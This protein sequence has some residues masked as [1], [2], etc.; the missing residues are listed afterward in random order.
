MTKHSVSHGILKNVT[1]NFIGSGWL[2]FLMFFSTPYIVRSFNVDLYGIYTL[3]FV[4]ISYLSF[5]QFG[6]TQATIRAI[7]Q[8]LALND[9]ENARI[10][11]WACM[12]F[13]IC[14]GLFGMT[15]I[16]LFAR[17]ILVTFAKIAPQYQSIA[18]VSLRIS[19]TAFLFGVTT[20]ALTGVLRALGRF[21]IANRIS[22]GTG[23]AQIGGTV[24]LLT[25]HYSLIHIVSFVALVQLSGL[26]VYS[27]EVYKLV[28]WILHP[29]WDKN[30]FVK[31]F[32]FGGF[33]SIISITDPIMINSDKIFITSLRSVASLT[34]YSIPY[35]IVSRLTIIPSAFM[36]VMF[37]MFSK[38]NQIKDTNANRELYIRSILYMMYIYLIMMFFI[39]TFGKQFLN[40]WIGEDFAVRSSIPLYILT[41]SGFISTS[42]TPSSTLLLA[43]GRPHYLALL[44]VIETIIYVPVSYMLIHKYGSTGAASALLLCTFL[45]AT[46]LQLTTLKV[47]GIGRFTFLRK[48][49]IPM[50]LPLITG[51]TLFF[52]LH[53]LHMK[54]T[55]PLN[56]LSLMIIF[57]IYGAVVWHTGLDEFAR[58]RLREFI[59][60]IF[61]RS[62]EDSPS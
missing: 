45:Y 27:Y 22:I 16:M 30:A 13:Y 40:L 23:T 29:S 14:I 51:G 5:L 15:A 4:V 46:A 53:R 34:Y 32:K 58:C 21:D 42:A 49:F 25:F 60:S 1:W 37:P 20:G 18:I 59:A 55:A 54:L 33:V 61:S 12:L 28:P 43:V 50:V 19:S 52:I 26:L 11:F 31:L 3:V 35:T 9:T 57:I 39:I 47:V 6:L 38:M 24:A 41:I 10:S 62:K 7:A 17:Y 48:I 56:L 2:I 44:S 36:A 8:H